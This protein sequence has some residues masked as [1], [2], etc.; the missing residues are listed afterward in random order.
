MCICYLADS[1]AVH[2]VHEF[3]EQRIYILVPTCV[4]QLQQVACRT[5]AALC[6]HM[7][8]LQEVALIITPPV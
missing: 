8:L 2:L 7:Q 1:T 4:V 5:H 6:Y 3:L